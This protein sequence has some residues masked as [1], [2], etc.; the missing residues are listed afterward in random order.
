MPYHPLCGSNLHITPADYHLI[1]SS[2]C[3]GKT[4]Y[5]LQP[6][7]PP[8]KSPTCKQAG[9]QPGG[10]TKC[11]TALMHHPLAN[12]QTECITVLTH[13]QLVNRQTDKMYHCTHISLMCEVR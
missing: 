10:Q 9:R 4:S 11:I 8:I 12:S 3:M 2:A 6:P 13:H 7:T 5:W 1:S